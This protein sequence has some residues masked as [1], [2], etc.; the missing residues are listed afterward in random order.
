[1]T[2]IRDIRRAMNTAE[3]FVRNGKGIIHGLMIT[4]PEHDDLR[5]ICYRAIVREVNPNF[6]GD[7]HEAADALYQ[8]CEPPTRIV[9]HIRN[10]LKKLEIEYE[11]SDV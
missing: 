11:D 4:E 10:A 8:I 9:A 6:E 3:A 7:R 2:D 5:H 1:M